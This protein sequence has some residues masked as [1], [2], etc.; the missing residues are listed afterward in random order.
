MRKR[1]RKIK[2]KK[3]NLDVKPTPVHDSAAK[4]TAPKEAKK[5]SLVKESKS[6]PYSDL[7][8]FPPAP[9][10]LPSITNSNTVDFAFGYDGGDGTSDLPP[11]VAY[12]EVDNAKGANNNNEKTAGS[13]A[14]DGIKSSNALNGA[15]LVIRKNTKTSGA[16]ASHGKSRRKKVPHDGDS[17]D[18]EDSKEVISNNKKT[19][20][21]SS[22]V[23]GR[24]KMLHD[25]VSNSGDKEQTNGSSRP[26]VTNGNNCHKKM[27]PNGES[28]NLNDANGEISMIKKT[29]G[30]S[31]SDGTY[32]RKKSQD[33]RFYV[34]KNKDCVVIDTQVLAM[35]CESGRYPTFN[36]FRGDHEVQCTLCKKP[37]GANLINCDFCKN[38]V[39]QLCLDR[40]MVS[41]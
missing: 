24:R 20:T 28:N 18:L 36:R 39:H 12:E 2:K 23:K 33:N 3:D 22:D 21:E 41:I 10:P 8:S 7:L 32:R 16:S 29:A 35:E 34:N 11:V 4:K 19:A 17:N 31:P 14:L 1:L 9:P 13:S 25:G 6:S 26:Y 15:Q 27:P 5:K 37:E 40:R 38:S 30:A